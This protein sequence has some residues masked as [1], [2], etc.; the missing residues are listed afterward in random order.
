MV[1]LLA[2]T[3]YRHFGMDKEPVR[4]AL[5]QDLSDFR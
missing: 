1:K 2:L 4:L 5:V 3:V